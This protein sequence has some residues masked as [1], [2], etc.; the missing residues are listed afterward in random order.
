MRKEPAFTWDVKTKCDTITFFIYLER[1][2]TGNYI[3]I[4]GALSG[5]TQ[6]LATEAFLKLV[7]NDL[8][9]TL[10]ARLILNLIS[11]VLTSQPG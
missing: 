9:Y 8:N 3:L 2:V 6:F 7:K 11:N 5:L 1:I 10:K 4:K